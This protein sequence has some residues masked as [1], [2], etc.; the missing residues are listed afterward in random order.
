MYGFVRESTGPGKGIYS[1]ELFFR[2]KPK[3]CHMM[4]R[5][6][7]KSQC[8]AY[9]PMFAPTTS[10]AVH[11]NASPRILK[12]D[13]MLTTE[14][15][16]SSETMS[17]T[18]TCNNVKPTSVEHTSNSALQATNSRFGTT[19]LPTSADLMNSIL[20]MK[21]VMI[22]QGKTMPG[23]PTASCSRWSMVN[24]FDFEPLDLSTASLEPEFADELLQILDP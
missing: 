14:W 4:V 16:R 23:Y 13:V 9:S 5:I 8:P 24:S 11:Q 7:I 17:S 12:E 3:M 1:H 15:G 2:G 20:E 21:V 10:P 6:K 18:T 19:S 22:L